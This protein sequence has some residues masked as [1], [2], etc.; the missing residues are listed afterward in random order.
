MEE[1]E[2]TIVDVASAVWALVVL[3]A[4]LLEALTAFSDPAKTLDV[5]D[6]LVALE[7]VE[8]A[9]AAAAAAAVAA[10]AVVDAVD[11]V[12]WAEAMGGAESAGTVEALWEEG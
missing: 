7:G 10:V 8:H 11:E 5:P 6:V 12:A 9:A 2:K 3:G 4:T 1:I